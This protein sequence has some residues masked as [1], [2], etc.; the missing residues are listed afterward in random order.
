M[1]KGSGAREFAIDTIVVA[2]T[3]LL[4]KLRGLVTLPLIVKLLGTGAYG[5]WSQVLAF[6][7]FVGALLSVN[8]HIPL[9]RFIAADRSRAAEVYSTLLVATIAF[10]GVG[11]GL[12]VLF[13]E[14][15]GVA[16]LD[17]RGVD[18][19]L[20]LGALLLVIT[21]LRSLNLNVYRATG[22]LL[23]RSVIELVNA[24][25]EL[26]GIYVL[27]SAGSGLVTV[28]T[29]M[30]IW[31]GAIVVG[32]TVHCLAITGW[33]AP[34]RRALA[35]SLRYAMPLIP[36]AFSTWALDR[37]DRFV[38]GTY[39][40]AEGVGIYSANYALAGMLMMFQSPFQVTLL[41]KVASLWDVDRAKAMRYIN[42]ANT[43]FLTLAIPFVVGVP[44]LAPSLLTH[45]GNAQIGRAAGLTTA[46]IGGGILLWG[47]S[48]MQ[49]QIFHGAKQ[50]GVVGKVTV[51]TALVNLVL[52]F[53]LVPV[54]GVA[55][56]ALATLIA[57]AATC[58]AFAWISREIE[59][60]AI[61]AGHMIGCVAAAGS[62]G[63][64]LWL[65]EPRTVPGLIGAMAGGAAIYFVVLFVLRALF[66]KTIG[67]T[68]IPVGELLGRRR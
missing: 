43:V 31:E 44:I 67:A 50:P 39:L 42:V 16:L 68:R 36:A 45:L 2:V 14:P 59:M 64:F 4:L 63:A 10:A 34:V 38:I 21:N 48:I 30:V 7:T 17:A 60:L 40:G 1:A 46:F 27:L 51:A 47:V 9:V 57:Y 22:R 19:Y 3:Q 29:F 18:R 33:T 65:I 41:P 52:N 55:G 15:V 62:M 23:V 26:V 37:I 54:M 8:L 24:V 13:S 32:Q 66:P 5:I 20:Q 25:G 49:I 53:V 12:V 58:A 28:F 6:V 56:A 11:A 61:D 35:E